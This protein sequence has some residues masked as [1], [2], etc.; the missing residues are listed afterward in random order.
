MPMSMVPSPA[1]CQRLM[2]QM[3]DGIEEARTYINAIYCGN[4]RL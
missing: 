1:T 3:L 2:D 4:C